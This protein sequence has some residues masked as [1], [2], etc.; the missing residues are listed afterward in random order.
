MNN[1]YL[2]HL[3]LS[4]IFLT[5]LNT[6]AQCDSTEHEIYGKLKYNSATK[7]RVILDQT[8]PVPPEGTICKM[9]KY[10]ETQ[11]FGFTSTGWLTI[12]TIEAGTYFPATHIL[13]VKVKE[14]HSDITVNGKKKN[15]FEAGNRVRLNWKSAPELQPFVKVVNDDTLVRGQLL[16]G[17]R[18]GYWEYYYENGKLQERDFYELGKAD[19]KY[20]SYH[21]NG[22]IMEEGEYDM[23]KRVGILRSFHSNG[24]PRRI[25]HY[26]DGKKHGIYQ[27]FNKEGNIDYEVTYENDTLT[28]P[29][30]TFY[31]N[32][33]EKEV[34]THKNGKISGQLRGY[35]ETGTLYFIS[36]FENDQKNGKYFGYYKSG[37]PFNETTYKDDEIH[38][39]YKEFHENGQVA[40]R[41]N[42][43]N[44]KRTV[45]LSLILTTET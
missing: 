1:N 12:A 20:T 10:F 19:G 16:C 14:E 8:V 44:G 6:L 42:F 30:V 17:E 9:H 35:Y 32:G 40:V 24:N 3:I 21:D 11:L 43:V 22:M 27:R 25:I 18:Q 33:C 39:E 28:G 15:H 5:G 31:D 13:E 2:H 29:F 4:L 36:G 34:G 7:V 38:G 45:K 37:D 41:T 26:E 23:G